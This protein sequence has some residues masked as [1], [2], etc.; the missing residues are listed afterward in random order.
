MCRKD[1]GD[2]LLSTLIN[3]NTETFSQLV[4]SAALEYSAGASTDSTTLGWDLFQAPWFN[5]HFKFVSKKRIQLGPGEVTTCTLRRVAPRIIRSD[6]EGD[7]NAALGVKGLC[8]IQCFKVHGAPA[9]DATTKTSATVTS[10][11][12]A[13]DYTVQRRYTYTYV[14]DVQN[15]V[16]G[17]IN[18]LPASFAV[19]QSSMNEDTGAANTA[20]TPA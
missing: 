15:T 12:V 11:N 7:Q 16:G 8:W 13:L 10:A 17:M 20:F 9:N 14:S 6:Y 4:S 2:Y 19:N 5:E 1:L 18:N 3:S